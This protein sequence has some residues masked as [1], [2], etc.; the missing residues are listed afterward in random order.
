MTCAGCENHV[1]AGNVTVDA[2]L[3]YNH[4]DVYKPKKLPCQVEMD[5]M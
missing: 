5:S 1:T 4:P 2:Q 3:L